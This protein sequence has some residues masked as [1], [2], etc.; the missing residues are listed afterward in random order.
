TSHPDRQQFHMLGYARRATPT[1]TANG[2]AGQGGTST[3]VK[4]G[5]DAAEHSTLA[6]D[7]PTTHADDPG[8][9]GMVTG[10][11]N[12]N[13]NE[14][15]ANATNDAAAPAAPTRIARSQ[16]GVSVTDAIES[17]RPIARSAMLPPLPSPR[18]FL[19]FRRPLV[20]PATAAPSITRDP[21][22]DIAVNA[23]E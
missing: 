2:S 23:S 6:D 10:T 4:Q 1:D 17:G 16:P 12:T 7:H 18:P 21:T 15:P 20:R 13:T 5:G 11:V 19:L 9:S 14:P 8:E 3:Y 22:A